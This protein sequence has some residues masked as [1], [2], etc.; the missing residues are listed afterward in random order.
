M[1]G[2]RCH[3]DCSN[4]GICDYSTGRCKCFEGSWG[5][6]CDLL[7]NTGSGRAGSIAAA[8]GTFIPTIDGN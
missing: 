1:K 3:V 5:V 7:T 6:A 4:R 2:N 8:N